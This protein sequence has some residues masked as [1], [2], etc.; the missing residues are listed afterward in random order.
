MNTLKNNTI[1][2]AL[3]IGS[4]KVACIVGKYN[5][6]G[7]ME[8]LGHENQTT[9]SVKK[10]LII[11][12]VN[13]VDEIKQVVNSVAK[14]TNTEI[15]SVIVNANTLNSKSL[16][17]KGTI[18]INDEQVDD[19]HIKSAINKSGIYDYDEE[20]KSLHE[21]INYFDTDNE[22]RIINPKN[23]FAN[24]LTVNI[25]QII[26]KKNYFK[27]LE[28]ILSDANLNIEYLVASPF[29]S[30]LA[31]LIKDEKE[32]GT[33]CIDLGAGITSVCIIENNS[34]VFTGGISV[35]SSNITYDIA[36]GLTTEIES[37]ER[38]K[39]LYGSV[40]SNPSDEYELIDVPII[41]SDKNQFNQ[42]NRS[43]LNSFIKPR[44]EET[45]ELVR[46]RLKE[47]NLHKKKY[48]R[49]V[50][51]GGGSLLEGIDEYAKVIFDSQVRIACPSNISG[52]KDNIRK[53][54]FSTALGSLLVGIKKQLEIS[55]FFPEKAKKT[56]KRG[57]FGRFYHWL[58]HYI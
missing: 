3:D 29:A 40:F 30:S 14:K 16:Y 27:S 45:L 33:I 56:H 41:G 28:S 49:V 43:H 32:M 55:D 21:V 57:V 58:E 46:Q 50:L 10:G 9:K 26:I 42:I 24:Q 39:T 8:I 54:Q 44:V 51:T 23:L 11:D 18:E 22:K 35:G 19:L 7:I 47:Y 15:S 2:A 20:Y 5:N 12:S 17:L 31:T 25:Y 6:S 48:R 34:L 52:L 1:Y 53:P 37:A 13:I 36:S 4:S 38:L